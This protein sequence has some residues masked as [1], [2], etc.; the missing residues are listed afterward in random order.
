ME[1][2]CPTQEQWSRLLG[3]LSDTDLDPKWVHHLDHCPACWSMV[4]KLDAALVSADAWFGP[5]G[6]SSADIS[7]EAR[8]ATLSG[9]AVAAN[10]PD[11]NARTSLPDQLPPG[12]RLGHLRLLSTLGRGGM[13]SVYEAIDDRSSRRV[14]VKCLNPARRS[15]E[16]F[17][18]LSR[19]ARLLSQLQHP[20]IVQLFEF[21]LEHNP[22]YIVLELA[23]GGSLRRALQH[24][25]LNQHQ[26]A[27]L[28][29]AVA[30]AIHAAHEFGVLHLDLKPENI[31]LMHNPA[32][33]SLASAGSEQTSGYLPWVPKVADF[34]LCARLHGDSLFADTWR[35][36]RGTLAWMA[37]E[38]I[39]GQSA[40]FGRATDVYALGVILYELLTGVLPF[41]GS[42]DVELSGQICRCEPCPPR[43]LC[44]GIS[45]MLNR[46]C[47]RCL[48]KEPGRRFQTATELADELDSLTAG[49]MLRRWC[50][51]AS[52]PLR[53][54]QFT[55]VLLLQVLFALAGFALGALLSGRLPSFT[56]SAVSPTEVAAAE[57][58][59]V[60]GDAGR[61]EAERY[62]RELWEVDRALEDLH[63]LDIPADQSAWSRS[64]ARYLSSI[65]HNLAQE[66][67]SNPR[68]AHEVKETDPRVLL[69]ARLYQL[70]GLAEA[71][72]CD[73]ALASWESTEELARVLQ[74][75]NLLDERLRFR[76]F[77]AVRLVYDVLNR[78]NCG[79]DSIAVLEAAW[80]IFGPATLQKQGRTG[81]FEAICTDFH[82]YLL[83]RK[84]EAGLVT[85]SA[86]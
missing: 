66:I 17:M 44:P 48:H 61:S 12:S 82:Q 86:D 71:G 74:E 11:F 42:H 68:L 19:E 63:S 8:S 39:S 22:P 31:L 73:A 81:A 46:I 83:Q 53:Q 23:A 5:E 43:R 65:A 77:T 60:A 27:Q 52:R 56:V 64:P 32:A 30:R 4:G 34:G 14:A 33:D 28:V 18:G 50:R 7:S 38:Q 10:R 55:A 3:R 47:L 6:S 24:R 41:R 37:P 15:S 51:R 69:L 45:R 29:A 84:K 13:G 16:Y 9:S 1:T 35:R 76:G 70:T 58:A 49:A 54:P 78:R 62:V 79:H 67:L 85:S 72:L 21:D 80:H 57:V 40:D 26:C 36:P 59:A 75:R 2:S 25:T 20:N